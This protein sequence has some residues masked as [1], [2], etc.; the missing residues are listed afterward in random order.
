MTSSTCLRIKE[1]A[2]MISNVSND[3]TDYL[4][5]S[6][7]AVTLLRVFAQALVS[8]RD[9]NKIVSE[10]GSGKFGGQKSFF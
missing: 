2:R 3:H 9:K 8:I 4:R 5:S 7:R 6:L 1:P 10:F